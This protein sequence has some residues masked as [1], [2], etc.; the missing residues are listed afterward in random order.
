MN[1]IRIKYCC[2]PA[3]VSTFGLGASLSR[4][5]FNNSEHLV[6]TVEKTL[7]ILGFEDQKTDCLPPTKR[8]V[9]KTIYILVVR[10]LFILFL[11]L[12]LSITEYR[13]RKKLVTSDKSNDDQMHEESMSQSPTQNLRHRSDSVSSATSFLSSDDDLNPTEMSTKCKLKCNLRKARQ[14]VINGCRRNLQLKCI[15]SLRSYF[16]VQMRTDRVGEAA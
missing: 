6:G 15:F 5:L 8:K 3:D 4:P 2:A 13:Q 1:C 9:I 14:S 7:S 11:S 12:Q 16:G 10:K